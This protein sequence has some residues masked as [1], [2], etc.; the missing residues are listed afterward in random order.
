[1]N[2]MTPV[3]LPFFCGGIDHLIDL[4]I[5]EDMGSGDVTTDPLPHPDRLAAGRIVAKEPLVIAGL[6]IAKRVFEK[7]DKN[8]SFSSLHTEGSLATSGQVIAEV[9][10][11]IR[12]LL[13]GERTALNFL[14]R[15]CGIATHVRRLTDMVGAKP[16]R[17][18][19]TRKTI[20][21]WRVLEK[22]AVRVGGAHNHRMG[23]YDGVLIKDNHIAAFGGIS[24]AI[25]RVRNSVSHLMKIEIEVSN[26]EELNE[27]LEAGADIIMLDNMNIDEI[28]SAIGLIN[29]RAIVEVSGRISR[30]NLGLIADAGVDIISMGALTHSAVFVDISMKIAPLT[31]S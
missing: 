5:S 1:M 12:A 24:N 8:S 17:L 31:P 28:K 10:G 25:L 29:G 30:E 21:G 13:I 16:I 15:L 7:L 9:K 3:R 2:K 20:P 22:Y 26:F 11:S 19:D 6:D 4:A 14:Q 18:V 23:L 27:A